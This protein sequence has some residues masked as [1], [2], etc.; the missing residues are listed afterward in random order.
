MLCSRLDLFQTGSL[1]QFNE[2]DEC[3][4]VTERAARASWL[5][6]SRNRC[7]RSNCPNAADGSRFGLSFEGDATPQCGIASIL[8]AAYNTFGAFRRIRSVTTF[9]LSQQA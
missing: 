8:R 1:T 3:A 6:F 2:A 7:F 5:I 4:L 9:A